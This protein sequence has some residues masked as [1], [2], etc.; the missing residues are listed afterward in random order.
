M[1]WHK[2]LDQYFCNV[3]L[4]TEVVINSIILALRYCISYT[5]L[6][7]TGSTLE[8]L[9]QFKSNFNYTNYLLAVAL[10]L[11]DISNYCVMCASHERV[12]F[13]VCMFPPQG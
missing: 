8:A 12:C 3:L 2:N 11:G 10:D 5:E 7:T 9:V 4:E 13:F 1:Y 6:C